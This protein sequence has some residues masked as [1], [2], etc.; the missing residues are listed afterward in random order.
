MQSESYTALV[1]V[2]SALVRAGT[3]VGI[4]NDTDLTRA[5]DN[6][7]NWQA[8][9]N[10]AE[11]H[12]LS[13]M[14][15]RLV[16]NREIGAPRQLDLQLKALTIRHQK[17]LK[18]REIVL[19]EGITLFEDNRIQFAFLKG[20]ALAQLIYEPPWLRPMRDIDILVSA[21]NAACAQ[22]L[23]R[24][25]G[26]ENEDSVPGYLYEHH[27]LP[28]SI[29][30]QDGFTI[31]LEVHH[32]AL[33]GDVDASITLDHLIEPLRAFPFASNT[34]YAF[35]HADML[36]H[37]CYHSFEPAETIKLGSLV[38]M[39]RYASHYAD[40]IDW[41]AM[42]IS[43][44]NICNALRCIH[45]LIPLPQNLHQPLAPL[46]D[47]GWRPSGLGQGFIP[48]SKISSLGRKQKIRALLAPPAW[49]MHI[50]YT[51]PPGKSLMV[52]HCLQHPATL[53]K[54]VF[55]RYKA[56]HKSTRH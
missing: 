4:E 26:F 37:L 28:N 32:D 5:F 15:G 3:G 7:V 27:H 53:L 30:I 48:L 42:Q 56:A 23:L 43:Q 38:D 45:A 1:S 20:A 19:A 40:E 24:E 55:R 14:L 33:S 47:A 22:A 31:S 44:P 18:A 2:A 52:V 10:Q 51:V 25:V 41:Q 35:G 9:A 46:P 36:K 34:A 39:V 17:I 11:L 21:E 29:R 49:W 8:L 12:G 54:W 13:V 6:V 50:F 16:A